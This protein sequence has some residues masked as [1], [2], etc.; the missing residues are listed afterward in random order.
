MPFPSSYLFDPP[1][2]GA[3]GFGLAMGA[4]FGFLAPVTC[5]AQQLFVTLAVG[6]LAV[7]M[8]LLLPRMGGGTTCSGRNGGRHPRLLGS[9]RISFL[10]RVGRRRWRI[11]GRG[12]LRD[13][14]YVGSLCADRGV[15]RRRG[16]PREQI[17]EVLH[18]LGYGR[19]LLQGFPHRGGCWWALLLLVCDGRGSSY[20]YEGGAFRR[21]GR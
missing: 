15:M 16:I 4:S 5:A 10:R 19:V 18:G 8:F 7:P 13:L 12:S 3:L 21:R 11:W 6:V 1:M 20:S 17:P 9:L 2:S 14:D